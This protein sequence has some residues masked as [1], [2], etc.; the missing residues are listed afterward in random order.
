MRLLYLKAKNFLSFRDITIP[1]DEDL[2]IIVGPNN[3]GK[4]NV[5]RALKLIA[6]V[7]DG[8][9]IE[10]IYFLHD[11]NNRYFRLE[12]GYELSEE[13]RRDI[14]KFLEVYYT[15]K[16]S[17]RDFGYVP[18]SDI[19]DV[20]GPNKQK[21]EEFLN[22]ISNLFKD[23]VKEIPKIVSELISNGSII[24]E[25]RAYESNRPYVSF[26][27]NGMSIFVREDG[28]YPEDQRQVKH[29]H[30]HFADV[31][32][33]QILTSPPLLK[34]VKGF[35]S[36]AREEFKGLRIGPRKFLSKIISSSAGFPTPN[37]RYDELS[38]EDKSTISEITRRHGI[39]FSSRHFVDLLY[40][41]LKMFSTRLV[42]LREIREEPKT[43]FE[44]SSEITAKISEIS[45][46]G[47]KGI[48]SD[49]ALSLMGL[50]ISED[51]EDRENYRIIQR[52][53][54]K[55]TRLD[56][57]VSSNFSEGRVMIW[58]Q[59][60]NKQIPI[61]CVGSGL[62]E[63]LN[64]LSVTIG[65]KNCIVVLDEPA[66][67]LHPPKQLDILSEIRSEAEKSKNQL[68]IIT[69]SP[70]FITSED[71]GK[72]MRFLIKDGQTTICK[73]QDIED[74]EILRLLEDNPKLKTV[75]FSNGVILA[76][77]VAETVSLPNF[78]R[79]LDLDLEERNIEIVNVGA[80]TYFWKYIPILEDFEIPWIIL[81]DGKAITK[82]GKLP[83]LFGQL[84]KIKK[85]EESDKRRVEEIVGGKREYEEFSDEELN[86][87]IEIA[88][89]YKIFVFRDDDF[90]NF[91][92]RKF[93]KE[94]SQ[95]IEEMGYREDKP[96]P[97]A[98]LILSQRLEPE[99][100][101]KVSEF[102]EL[103]KFIEQL[104]NSG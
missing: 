43:K 16:H 30:D 77:G 103:K 85:L 61:N 78:L 32:K 42:I 63:L 97:E 72:V 39:E 27:F 104:G 29:L 90:N 7:V 64:I 35:L 6:D 66:A 26:K 37:F 73:P 47:Y 17:K 79:K 55:L 51:M 5:V 80:D 87:L 75:L 60:E 86:E 62:L 94:F 54:E 84:N 2:N 91:L 98:A 18:W 71:L 4:T 1:L 52:I 44:G 38:P 13:E 41:I 102:E 28:I 19:F 100:V 40:L 3:S 22:H 93:E 53:F 74:P 58:I 69:H 67:H 65:N 25:Y 99:E 23:V 83:K 12:V 11:R 68:I 48:G 45:A 50:K 33:D 14:A 96:K 46:R 82:G 34:E 92:K 56:F 24:F 95:I 70:Y 20:R 88:K 21:L 89:K 31:I 49:L 59:K 8:E 101:R 36:G 9:K 76:E 81:C 15:K 10:G 57:D